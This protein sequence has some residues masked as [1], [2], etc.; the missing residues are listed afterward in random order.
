MRI[1]FNPQIRKKFIS[2]ALVTFTAFSSFAQTDAK[3]ILD[4]LFA[5]PEYKKE[6]AVITQMRHDKVDDKKILDYLETNYAK[7]RKKQMTSS[8]IPKRVSKSDLNSVLCMGDEL[9]VELGN[10]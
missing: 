1:Y 7:P 2:I 9:G 10:F 8:G 4:R 5:N 3:R 6:C